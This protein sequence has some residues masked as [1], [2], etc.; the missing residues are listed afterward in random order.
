MLFDWLAHHHCKVN[1][2][3]HDCWDFTGHCIYFTYAKCNQWS[4]GCA[5]S[6]SCPQKREYPESWFAGDATVRKNWED[7][8]RIFTSL[9][10]ERVQLITPSE[11]LASLVRKSFLSK[12]NVKV[13]HNTINTEVFKPTP[14]DFRERYGLGDRF[15]VLGVASKWSDR[16]GLQDFVQ[17]ARDLDDFAYEF[18]Y[19]GYQDAVDAADTTDIK[20]NFKLLDRI[21]GQMADIYYNQYLPLKSIEAERKCGLFALKAGDTYGYIKSV[22]MLSP[23]FVP[24]STFFALMVMVPEVPVIAIFLIVPVSSIIPVNMF[25]TSHAFHQICRNDDRLSSCFY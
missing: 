22:E 24:S 13:V 7:K 19:Y 4:T 10:S 9:P 12:Y 21:Y 18:D 3:L 5:F 14:S 17:L 1:W 11:W 8:R 15:V 2:T 23:I 16:K 25:H 6:D 20:C